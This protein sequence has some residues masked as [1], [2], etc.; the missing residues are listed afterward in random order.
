MCVFGVIDETVEVGVQAFLEL[1]FVDI[2]GVLVAFLE[3]VQ[4]P[5]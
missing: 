3:K 5:V 1:G 2:E 4:V